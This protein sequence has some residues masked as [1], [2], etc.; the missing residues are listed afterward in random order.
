MDCP[1]LLKL[2][3]YNFLCEAMMFCLTVPFGVKKCFSGTSGLA[4]L[5]SGVFKGR[6]IPVGVKFRPL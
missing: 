6:I 2:L 5:M 1:N 4:G 3:D